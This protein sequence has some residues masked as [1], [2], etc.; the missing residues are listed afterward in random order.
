MVE[1]ACGAGFL[2]EVLKL[3]FPTIHYCGFDLNPHLLE[4]ARRRLDEAPDGRGCGSVNHFRCANLVTDDWTAQLIEMGWAGKVDAVVSIQALHDLGELAQQ[5][6][7][8]KLARRLL[9]K[10]GLLAYGD[11][12]YD[13]D[14]PHPSRHSREEHEE[15]LRECGFAIPGVSTTEKMRD[16][17]DS[18][19][20]AVATIGD[21]GTFS[22]RK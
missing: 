4:F 19:G 10:G 12:L 17:S 20:Y 13:A 16:H 3:R 18:P 5:K 9:R 14:E 8:L 22:C 2:A 6:Q 7:V 1:L 11:L 15:M 21:F